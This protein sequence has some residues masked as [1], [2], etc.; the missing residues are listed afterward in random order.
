MAQVTTFSQ[1]YARLRKMNRSRYA[2]LVG[3]CVFSVLLIAAYSLMMR[4]P[5][6]MDVL[7]E[8]G[9]SRKQVSMIFAL[10]VIGCGVFTTYAAGLF[11]REKSRETGIF[12]ALG[13]SR[14]QLARELRKDLAVIALGSCVGG[15]VLGLPVA[16]GIWQIFRLFVVDSQEMALRM[17]PKAY[18]YVLA[19][20]LYVTVMLFFLGNRS[21]RKTNIIDVVQESHK[22]E[23]IRAVPRKYGWLGIVLV[24]IG[25][26]LG[27][28]M[29]V[30]FVRVLH[31]Y[32]P[33][34]L[35]AVFYVPAIVG[36]YMVLLHTVG[37]GW[38]GKRKR[39]KD[40]ISVSMM[41]FQARQTVRNMLV[42]TLLIA[43][44][45]FASF[46]VPMLGSAAMMQSQSV[47]I[48][49]LFHYRADQ[50]MVNEDDI[51]ALADQ[52]GVTI[53]SYSEAPM[54]RLVVDG[55]HSVEKETTVGTTYD[56]VYEEE[57]QSNLF[58]SESGYYALSGER[59]D[60][61]PGTVV[62]ILTTEGSDGYAFNGS[63]SLI[64]NSASGE[65]WQITTAEPVHNDSLYGH[66]VLD[67]SDYAAMSAGLSAEWMENMVAFNVL[68]VDST[69]DFA[70]ALFN[71]IID[72]SDENVQIMDAWDPVI[73]ER[74]IAETGEYF[75]DPQ[76]AEKNG[77]SNI[78]YDNRDS[79]DFRTY[80]QY[81]PTFRV[82]DQADF[83]KTYAVFLML[84]IFIA[85]VC[86]AA[87]FVIAYTRCLTIALT[88]RQVYDDLRHLGAPPAYLRHSAGSQVRRVFV[89][90][91][92]LGTTII[93][94]FYSMIMFFNDSRFTTSELV[95]LGACML[96]IAA[97]SVV[98]WG[99]Y[100][101]TRSKVYRVLQLR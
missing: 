69:Y 34:A 47:P 30:F 89:T 91:A 68:D 55:T 44:A 53:T 71:A 19:F 9:D 14:Q 57:E 74:D 28:I 60:V 76:N 8:G 96:V 52:Y 101:M 25:A 63:P 41:K 84:F 4:A 77:F 21:V 72:H 73:R 22:S 99:V 24:A 17:D 67:D 65:R 40:I 86:F 35:D 2:L 66:Y 85:I 26:F 6:V 1:V 15:A 29:P 7:P 59:I 46:Y 33:S 20:A 100:R 38:G 49:Y 48:D 94:A 90:P 64:T 39:Y 56:V 50:D 23:P 43:G 62:P 61:Q 87:V 83:V 12:L 92:V 5:T 45:Y 32:A 82:L 16:A 13:A 80:W 27:Y 93:F 81:M 75:A 10:T 88:N 70:D 51:R 78:S 18:V 11:F 36:L 58:L 31:W 37:N 54:A 42:M 97:I 95:G 3:C 98:L 79:T